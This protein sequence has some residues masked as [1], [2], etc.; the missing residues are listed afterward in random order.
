MEDYEL[1]GR[2]AC[3]IYKLK[4]K[5]KEYKEAIGD[6]CS[7]CRCIGGP[8]NDNILEFNHEQK[9]FLNRLINCIDFGE[10]DNG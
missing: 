7:M 2:Q 10:H 6:A 9:V 1:I 4:A 5:I 3:E 8:L